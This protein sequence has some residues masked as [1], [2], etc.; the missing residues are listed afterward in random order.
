MKKKVAVLLAA[1]M[2]ISL[3]TG[4]GGKESADHTQQN[5]EIENNTQ[6]ESSLQPGELMTP[7]ESFAGGDGTKENPYQISNAAEW[8][9]FGYI[10]D[11]SNITPDDEEYAQ[12]FD[13]KYYIL[14]DDIVI[15]DAADYENW[16]ENPPK[17]DWD[18]IN[19]FEGH[20]DG[21]GHTITGFY[22]SDLLDKGVTSA[23][24]FDWLYVGGVVE[25]LNLEKALVVTTTQESNGGVIAANV[26][27]GEIRNCNVSGMVTGAGRTLGGIAGGA[28]WTV[29]ENCAFTGDIYFTGP[30]IVNAGGIVGSISG[31][32]LANCTNEGTI[33]SESESISSL[34]GIAGSF[35]AT[36]AGFLL[37]EETYPEEAARIEKII[38]SVKD[39]G[40][41]IKNCT[42]TGNI[43]TAEGDAGGIVGLISDGLGHE[44]R[45][46]AVITDCI[47]EGNVTSNDPNSLMGS[48]GGI[49]GRYGTEAATYEE[50]KTI[51]KLAFKNCINKGNVHCASG[52]VAGVLAGARLEFGELSFDNCTNLGTLSIEE[53]TVASMG[54]MAGDINVFE[55]VEL[56]F[57]NIIDETEYNV[58]KNCT[59]GG[60]VGSVTAATS[61]IGELTFIMKNCQGLG[62]FH[63]EEE[64]SVLS[65]R[66]GAL[67]GFFLE[68]IYKDDFQGTFEI[69]SCKV[70]DGVPAVSTQCSFFDT[71]DGMIEVMKEEIEAEKE[72]EE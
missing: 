48:A 38:A 2:S 1:M 66:Y 39:K 33:T 47:N 31:G 26:Q 22:C 70:P 23:G 4:C 59:A 8:Y 67:C 46:L 63:M 36:S 51:G 72:V 65:G 71:V 28:S 27:E 53:A 50:T 45:D 11:P 17:Y 52:S 62:T 56:R 69:I 49:C 10:L 16:L 61:D 5:T 6:A 40:V 19:N 41:G 3:L 55:G 24:I 58:I 42:N 34:G 43:T 44:Y 68:G 21:Q 14:T 9:R 25:N 20:L 29:V 35:S 54:G 32:V 37:D 30:G 15:N 60:M 57:E 18:P 13:D 64:D 12:I 7:A